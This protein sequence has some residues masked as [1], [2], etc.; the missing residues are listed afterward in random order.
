MVNNPYEER[1]KTYYKKE[2]YYY[3]LPDDYGVGKT[4]KAPQ[5]VE[6]TGLAQHA[7]VYISADIKLDEH[8]DFENIQLF[9]MICSSKIPTLLAKIPKNVLEQQSQEFEIFFYIKIK[10]TLSA[11]LTYISKNFDLLHDDPKISQL[12]EDEL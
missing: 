10:P 11:I 2:E 7:L 1:N 5:E 3:Q 12:S 8:L 6:F 9:P 4:G